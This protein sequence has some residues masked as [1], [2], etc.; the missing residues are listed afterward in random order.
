MDFSLPHNDYYINIIIIIIIT[1]IIIIII[2]IPFLLSPSGG[3]RVRPGR[4]PAHCAPHAGV[5]IQRDVHDII[6]RG[7]LFYI[8]LRCVYIPTLLRCHIICYTILCYVILYFVT[9]Y[10]SII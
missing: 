2:I 9:S 1:I 3:P 4:R 10:Y 7:L 6:L 8:I 5:P